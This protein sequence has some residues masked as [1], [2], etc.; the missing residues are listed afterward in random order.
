MPK[1][2]NTPDG[3]N[4]N[5]LYAKTSAYTESPATWAPMSLKMQAVQSTVPKVYIFLFKK[6]PEREL[7]KNREH[8]TNLGSNGP[9]SI[10]FPQNIG[11]TI[12]SIS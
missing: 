7:P 10:D 11:F 8:F 1:V 6:I 9:I 3:Y 2:T 5:S 12:F 4:P